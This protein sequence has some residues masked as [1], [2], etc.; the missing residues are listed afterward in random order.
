MKIKFHSYIICKAAATVMLMLPFLS[1]PAQ[2][3]TDAGPHAPAPSLTETQSWFKRNHVFDKLELGLNLGT[4][5]IGLEVA[6]P[7]TRW[8]RLRAG[9][10]MMPHF[11][12][13]SN[14]D[15]TAYSNGQV[16]EGN[17]DKVKEFMYEL[18]GFEMDRTVKMNNKFTLQNWRVLLDVFPIPDNDHWRVT[19]GLFGGSKVIGKTINTMTEMPTLLTLGIYNRMYDQITADDFVEY[20]FDNKFLGLFYLDLDAAEKLHDKMLEMD[21]LGIH[22][23]DFKDGTPYIMEPAPDGTVSAKAIVNRVRPYVGLGYEGALSPDKRWHAGVDAGVMI[24]GGAPK[25]YTHDGTCLNDL[26][27]LRSKVKDYMNLMKGL[28][29]YPVVDFRLSYTF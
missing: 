26:I 29:V 4:T 6:T 2:E 9:Y 20:C 7:I 25:V 1:S 23:G 14:F 5:G 22:V 21:R 24:W 11:S 27:N 19:V 28:A 13:K 15:I 8:T 17:F 18:S 12:F 16:T 10:D 3:R